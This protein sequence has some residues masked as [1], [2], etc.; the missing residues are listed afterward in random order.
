[1]QFESRHLRLHLP[2]LGVLQHVRISGGGSK[3]LVRKN[4]C[5]QPSKHTSAPST[6][7]R[8]LSDTMVMLTV[9]KSSGS[10]SDSESA[11]PVADAKV[12]I[13]AVKDTKAH[14]KCANEFL[15]RLGMH[16]RPEPKDG[17]CQFHALATSAES[18]GWDVGDAS[19]VRRAVCHQLK[20]NQELW[21]PHVT[22]DYGDYVSKMKRAGV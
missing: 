15:Q 6:L 10:E 20:S 11:K 7:S 5:T 19:E 17:N 18:Q 1:M 13:L 22:E 8:T 21:E 4:G 9:F 12:Q 16:L 3:R 2:L 14:W